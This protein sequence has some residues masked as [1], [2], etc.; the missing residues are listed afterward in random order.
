[1]A[2]FVITGAS[3]GVGRA[4]ALYF[5]EKDNTVCVLARKKEA[6]Q[7]LK[8]ENPGNIHPYA[9]DVTD[10]QQVWKTFEEI[11]NQEGRI[12]VLI[13]NAGVVDSPQDPWNGEMVD[14]II[15]TNLK[16]T[17]YCTY[18][19][20]PIMQKHQYGSIFNVA[21]ISGVD[22]SESGNNGMYA[23]SKYGVVAF[24]DSIGRVVRKD[25]IL[26]TT[27]CPGGINT[28]LWNEDNPYPFDR[29]VM[30][31]PEEIADLIDYVLQQPR[32]T[33]FKNIIF[34]PTVEKW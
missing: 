10:K 25:G 7:Q 26:V 20:I 18:A 3:S 23:A 4:C 22:I 5:A 32:R 2:V 30:I 6:L 1:M 13:N 34:V 28:P 19:A 11:G 29:D 8:Q 12:D 17:M 33:I 9:C 24:A 14:R 27:L 21:S 31:R 15:D 16:G